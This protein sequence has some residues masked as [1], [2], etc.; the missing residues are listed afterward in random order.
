MPGAPLLSR[1]QMQAL[2]R[3]AIQ[4]VGIPSL[5]LMEVAAR[6]VLD[7]VLEIR[8]DAPGPGAVLV[9]AGTGNN[10]GDAVCLARHLFTRDIPLELLVLGDAD[11]GSRE[12]ARQLEILEALGL[13][14]ARLSG[15]DAVARVNALAPHAS[16]VVDGLFGT[17]L[18]RAVSGWRGSVVEAVN[19]QDAPVVS[20]DIPSGLDADTGRVLGAAI[21]ASVTVT[22]QY[23]QP[24]H[25][26]YPGRACSGDL[27][28][29][30]IGLPPSRSA[31]VAPRAY[32]L[33]DTVIREAWVPRAPDTH[34]GTYG[35]LMVVAGVPDRPGAALL[36]ARAGLRAGAGLVTLGS[37]ATTVARLAPALVEIMGVSL[38]EAG[39]E[40]GA[41]LE[42]LRPCTALV[43][44]PSLPGGP[45]T[46][47]VLHRILVDSRLPV[48]L[49]AGALTALGE[50]F[51]RLRTRSAPCILTPHPGEMAR[52][53]GVD[54]RTVQE[55][56]IGVARR[57]A[58]ASGASVVLK[59]ASTVVCAPDG[60][61]HVVVR[62]NAGLASAGTGDVLAGVVGG[63][64]AQGVD[65]PLAA[66]AGAQLHARAGDLAAAR[67]GEHGMVASDLI[68]NLAAAMGDGA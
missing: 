47:E 46:Q 68:E 55:D 62:G 1:V 66:R 23:A 30:D 11:A 17:G 38:G 27:R 59:G 26:L 60:T 67:F 5:V 21:E 51:G 19:A 24:G 10:G 44:G 56:R 13:R 52:L 6:A 14:S 29:V 57:V 61:A 16:L 39:V 2:D 33:D 22:F 54:T 58:E 8:A 64:L 50:D 25:I 48:V 9:L 18:S 45:E 28:V 15:A 49:D 37:D 36:A 12:L 65:A 63:L 40:P 4:E 43:I 42:A 41:L 20:I 7:A 3:I 35:H 34:K 53:L 31:A 32:V